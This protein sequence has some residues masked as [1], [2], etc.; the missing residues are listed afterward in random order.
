MSELLIGA[1]EQ[2]IVRAGDDPDREGL[3]ETPE[4]FLKAWDFWTS[5]Y[6]QDPEAVIKTFVEQADKLDE[7]VFQGGITTASL[8]EHHLAPFHGVT[9]IAYI[10]DKGR[11]IGL[12]KF[13]RLVEIFARRLQVQER[14]CNQVADAL[15]QVLQPRA[16]GV[17]M[18]MRHSC[19]ESRGVQ[20]YGAVTITSALRG[21]LR[22]NGAARAEFFSLVN[23][24]IQNHTVL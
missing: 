17:V 20:K 12:S 4:R 2:L 3:R 7:L 10:P 19:M 22:T 8:C 6:K 16:V 24:A 5:G 21:V 14:L 1:I 9:H 23:T 11:I 13:S 18:Q 15:D